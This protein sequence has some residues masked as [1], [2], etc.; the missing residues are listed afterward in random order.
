MEFPSFFK[1][2]S[3]NNTLH[4]IYRGELS[5]WKQQREDKKKSKQTEK[6]QNDGDIVLTSNV[7]DGW[8]AC[9]LGAQSEFFQAQFSIFRNG[10]K[11]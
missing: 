4:N 6:L 3:W 10:S 8:K 2:T 9:K 1:S 11:A 5:T 7:D